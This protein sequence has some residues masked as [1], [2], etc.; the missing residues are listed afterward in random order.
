LAPA[1]SRRQPSRVTDAVHRRDDPDPPRR[2]RLRLLPTQT[3]RR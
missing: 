1:P 2:H 3:R